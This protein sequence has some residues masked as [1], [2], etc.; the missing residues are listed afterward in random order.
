MIKKFL[1]AFVGFAVVVAALVAVKASQIRT[2]SAVSHVP[3]PTAVTTV[4]AETEVWRPVIRAIGTLAPV[5]GVML[6]VDASG[7]VVKIAADNGSA[8]KAGD[9][10]VELDTTV[11]VA[12]LAAA[13]SRAALAKISLDRA[14]ELSDRNAMSKSDYDA[15]DATHQQAVADVAAIQAL[16]DKKTVRAPFDG[17]VGLRLVNLGQFVAQGAALLP[18]QKLDP[19]YVNFNVPQNQL[20]ALTQGQKADITV[21]AYPDQIFSATI[22]AINSEVDASTRN[23]SAQATLAN[24]QEL[25][26]AGMFA[27]VELELPSSGPAIV[28]PATA[29]AYA[30][31][32]NSVFIV[33]QMKDP[34]DHH[35]YLGV[36]Q[37]FVQLGATRGD[38]IAITDGVKPGEQVVTAGVFKLRNG[39]PVSVNN[40]AQPSASPTPK[41]ANT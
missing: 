28:V 26:R 7:T 41:P 29:I 10:L 6:S 2:L 39:A 17:R 30:S 8:V 16:I 24:P 15:A 23:I 40:D 18:L 37:Q 4:Q 21:D 9:L 35:E 12:Q 22:T 31:Y 25:L 5:E 1:I 33:E 11:E 32:G 38:L 19:I 20:A 34:V 3:P 13:Q 36:R 27:R 14:K